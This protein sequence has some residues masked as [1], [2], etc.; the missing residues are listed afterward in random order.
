LLEAMENE[1]LLF[2]EYR[3]LVWGDEKNLEN[4]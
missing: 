3:V 2:N 1:E 4:R